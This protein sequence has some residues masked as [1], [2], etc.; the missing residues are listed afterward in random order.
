M[1]N[2]ASKASLAEG[3]KERLLLSRPASPPEDGALGTRAPRAARLTHPRTSEI[4][5]HD[6]RGVPLSP[7]GNGA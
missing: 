3:D 7:P 5:L 2:R 1:I 6:S 4:L